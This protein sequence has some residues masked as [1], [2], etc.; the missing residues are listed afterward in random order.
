MEDP[1]LKTFGTIVVLIAV[2]SAQALAAVSR[3]TD[4]QEAKAASQKATNI[5]VEWNKSL[6]TIVRTPGAQPSTV[7][8]T[9][10]FAILHAAIYDAVNAIAKT[11]EPFLVRLPG[12]PHN[13]SQR[14][15]A[16]AA[17]HRVLVSL[18]P[19]FQSGLDN[20]LQQDLD[21]I[22]NSSRKAEGVR[23]GETVADHILGLRKNDGS[24]ATPSAFVP[25]N[26]PGDYQLTPPNFAPAQFTHWS[27]VT[28]FT[29]ERARQ[30]RPGPPPALTSDA[31]SNAFNEVKA[32]GIVN[33]ASATADQ[34]LTGRFWNGPIQNYWNEIAQT[35][36]EARGLDTAETA[37]LFALLDLA[38]ADSVIAFYD[39]KYTFNFWRPVTAIL[40]AGTDGNP[41]TTAD[42]NWVPEVGRTAPDPSYPGA[43]GVIS[44]AGV[45]VLASFFH[46]NHFAFT[47]TS[48]VL[49]GVS[50]SFTSFS[51]AATEASLSRIFAGQHFR[52]DQVAGNTLG[53]NV[54]DFVV[55]HFLLREGRDRDRDRDKRDEDDDR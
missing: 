1:V 34:A 32:N 21:Q 19:Q 51:D 4:D 52:F 37:R 33:S 6:L 31:Y 22:A 23:V 54:A 46:Q 36:S 27:H 11:H 39:A 24:D 13:A 18:Y 44:S 17:A 38:I 10:S 47:V 45:F 48:E 55:D 30:F 53:R 26:A 28:P 16:A 3:R 40:G 7:H 29:L 25:G 14:A 8:P 12:V 50:R 49:P 5:V 41:A 35:V 42:P 2:L 9:R 15:A 20:Q 43:H